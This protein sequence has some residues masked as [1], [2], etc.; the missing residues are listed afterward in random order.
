MY[1]QWFGFEYHR[2][3]YE[4]NQQ[5]VFEYILRMKRFLDERDIAF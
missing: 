4:K 1:R 3:Y 5:V 2:Y